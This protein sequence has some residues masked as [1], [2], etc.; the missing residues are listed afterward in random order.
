MPRREVTACFVGQ[1]FSRP[2]F[3]TL[4]QEDAPSA[5]AKARRRPAAVDVTRSADDRDEG[6]GV[7]ES[8]RGCMSTDSEKERLFDVR[9]GRTTQT[10]F[11]AGVTNAL[12][13]AFVVGRWPQHYF[14]L[15]IAKSLIMLPAITAKRMRNSTHLYLLEFCWFVNFVVCALSV[16]MVAA[17]L[18]PAHSLLDAHLQ[19]AWLLFFMLGTGPLGCSVAATGNA[20]LFHSLD[21]MSALF[22]H[23]A[24][25]IAAWCIRWHGPAVRH[26]YPGTT[27]PTSVTASRSHHTTTPLCRCP[28]LAACTLV[29]AQD[30]WSLV[31]PVATFYMAWW[32]PYAAW[33]LLDGIHQP[34]RGNKTVYGEFEPMVMQYAGVRGSVGAAAVYMLAHAVAVTALQLE[35]S[36]TKSPATLHTPH[37]PR[38]PQWV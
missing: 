35:P 32:V 34:A 29:D 36:T 31:L 13:T 5:F 4:P 1:I 9:S 11:A 8:S 30:T 20:M 2:R 26:A 16:C 27:A 33:L 15:M 25:M 24:P 6:I 22:I 21:H 10:K 12:M 3:S 18:L 17:L 7:R 14:M 37:S 28:G 19:Q 23:V 38:I